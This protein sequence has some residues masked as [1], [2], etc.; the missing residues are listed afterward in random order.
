MLQQMRAEQGTSTAA[1]LSRDR[2]AVWW[3]SEQVWFCLVTESTTH[4][5]ALG[6]QIMSGSGSYW[7]SSLRS[8]HQCLVIHRPGLKQLGTSDEAYHT[9]AQCCSVSPVGTGGWCWSQA[10]P[11]SDV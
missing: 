1:E 5:V 7:L 2:G 4:E 6:S 10:C 8:V 9:W 11:G 3:E